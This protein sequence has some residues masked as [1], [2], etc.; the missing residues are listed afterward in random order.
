MCVIPNEVDSLTERSR[1]EVV[2]MIPDKNGYLIVIEH[3]HKAE[4]HEEQ[5]QRFHTV[6]KSPSLE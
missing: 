1:K 4:N 5:H 3:M 6:V 2:K